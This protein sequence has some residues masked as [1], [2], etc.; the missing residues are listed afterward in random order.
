MGK[1]EKIEADADERKKRLERLLGSLPWMK[2]RK[3]EHYKAKVF[4]S[5]NS[6]ALRLPAG[7]HLAP[8]MEMAL[9]VEDDMFFSFEPIDP[10]KRK[11]NIAKVAGSATNLEPIRT[12]DRVF[13][14]RILLWNEPET[15]SGNK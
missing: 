15:G 4:K 12:E 5:G 3:K 2:T 10:P 1:H 7:L 9:S 13:G 14:E 11:F 6:L 8:G